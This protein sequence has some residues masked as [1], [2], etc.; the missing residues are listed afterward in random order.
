MQATATAPT[1]DTAGTDTTDTRVAVM[2]AFRSLI[3]EKG[4]TFEATI[5][6]IAER[7]P[8][9]SR[10]SNSAVYKTVRALAE[11]GHF[12][13]ITNGPRKPLGYDFRKSEKKA[14]TAARTTEPNI[15]TVLPSDPT[16]I[17]ETADGI[18]ARYH[19]IIEERDTLL[20]ERDQLRTEN[21]RLGEL[22]GRY[23][24]AFRQLEVVA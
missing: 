24:E 9:G 7:I 16:K 17:Q 2:N 14:K 6:D 13:L 12:E 23:D 15:P 3:E 10:P 18:L 4:A 19:Q 8:E 1:I 5:N 20:A 21:Q 11:D 22:V